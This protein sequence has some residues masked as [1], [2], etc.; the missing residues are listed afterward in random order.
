VYHEHQGWYS[1]ALNRYMHLQ[2]FGHAGARTLV[3]PTSMGGHNEWPDRRMHEVLRDHLDN[4]WIQMFC[5]DHVHGESWYAEGLHPGAMAWRH[6]QYLE[7][8]RAEVMPFTAS[9]NPNPFVI[10]TGASFGAYHA[11]CFG[12]RHPELVGRIIG[13]SGL[14]DIKRLTGGYSDQNVYACNPSDFMRHEW[15]SSRLD[16]FRRQDIVLAVGR[17]DPAYQNN[18]ELSATLWG[19]GI[20]N[21]L[22][23]WDGHAHDWPYWEKMIRLYIGGHD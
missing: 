10:A 15:E 14:Y 7:Y 8:I 13:M 22:R 19:K 1:P 18:C 11:A 9:R 5:L 16:A 21:A 2:V 23:I 17:D 3:F 6:L 20:G 4:G 12:F